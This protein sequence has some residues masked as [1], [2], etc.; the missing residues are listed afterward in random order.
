MSDIDFFIAYCK[1]CFHEDDLD[2]KKVSVNTFG[3]RCKFEAWCMKQY[4]S[5]AE[6]EFQKSANDRLWINGVGPDNLLLFSM[7]VSLAKPVMTI[8]NARNLWRENAD[9][10]IHMSE[11]PDDFRAWCTKKHP[12]VKYINVSEDGVVTSQEFVCQAPF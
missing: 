4:P 1:K 9:E 7:S 10:R 2:G 5:L 3:L 6:F 11:T 12:N 8:E